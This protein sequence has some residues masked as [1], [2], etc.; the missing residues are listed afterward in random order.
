MQCIGM[1]CTIVGAAYITKL[2]M[3]LIS[4]VDKIK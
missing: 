4:K 2:I 1:I 3:K